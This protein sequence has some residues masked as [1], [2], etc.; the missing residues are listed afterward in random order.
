[1]DKPVFQSLS[2]RKS[3]RIS[4]SEFVQLRDFIYDMTGIFIKEVRRYLLESRLGRRLRE[5]GVDSYADYYARLTHPLT[6]EA[7]LTCLFENIT[8]N[9][10]SFFR[11]QKQLEMFRSYPLNE[12]IKELKTRGRKELNI[13]SAGCSSGEEPYTI[14]MILYETLKM[15]IMGWRIRVTAGDLSPAMIRKAREGVYGGYSFKTTPDEM[16]NKYFKPTAS[17]YRVH[18][19]VQKLC[20]FDL[21]NLN[22]RPAIKRIPP[23]HIIF[24][25]NVIIY[26]DDDM[27]KRVIQSFYDNLIPGGYLILGHS[28]NIHALG[29]KFKTVRKIGGIYYQKP[30]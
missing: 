16:R 14:A 19:K 26:F 27:K 10:T 25:R 4:D 24:C 20:E 7:E 18:P 28:E 13:W 9:E 23:S 5:L 2:L 11:D 29:T 6:R 22:D 12:S 17:G 15:S 30:E 3:P 8:T 1:M 21:I